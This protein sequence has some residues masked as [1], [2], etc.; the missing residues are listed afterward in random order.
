MIRTGQVYAGGDAAGAALV[1]TDPLSFWGGVAVATGVIIDHSH[2]Q[3]G[4]SVAGRMLVMPCGRGSSSSSSVLA[5]C[6]RLGTGPVGILLARP[7]PILT[8]AALVA[9]ALY[10]LRC[11]IVVA[12]IAGIITGDQLRLV[13]TGA[14]AQVILTR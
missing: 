12:E 1:L 10:G 13:T 8:V 11:P 14:I 7:D 9:E 6:L 3:V 4:Q 2:P 5:E